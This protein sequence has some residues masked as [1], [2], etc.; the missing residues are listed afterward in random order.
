MWLL[1]GYLLTISYSSVL[2]AMLMSIYYE[3]RID[4]TDDMLSIGA[5]MKVKHGYRVFDFW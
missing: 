1:V 2:R 5:N 3:D 4:T